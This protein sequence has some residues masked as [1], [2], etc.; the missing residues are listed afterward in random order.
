VLAEVSQNP[1]LRES[2]AQGSAYSRQQEKTLEEE[3]EEKKRFVPPHLQVNLE[4]LDCVYMT[5]SMMLE[6][7]NVAENSFTVGQEVVSRNFRKLIETYDNKGVQLAAQNNRDHIFRAS[8]FLHKS[9]WQ[10]SF[11]TIMQIKFFANLEGGNSF[12]EALAHKLK[13]ISLRIYLLQSQQQYQ[14]YSLA[15]LEQAFELPRAELVKQVSR[16]IMSSSLPASIDLS[17]GCVV[18]HSQRSFDQKEIDYL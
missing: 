6:V 11:N 7:P 18:I 2:L 8:Q 13:E 5:T 3:I 1:K 10:Q 14:S 16:L 4:Q 17:S 15:S 12:R 9:Q